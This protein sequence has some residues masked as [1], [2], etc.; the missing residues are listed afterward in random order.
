[1]TNKKTITAILTLAGFKVTKIFT[2]WTGTNDGQ[3][4]NCLNYEVIASNE[5]KD[6][7]IHIFGQGYIDTLREITHKLIQFGAEEGWSY[8][9]EELKI[10]ISDN[11]LKLILNDVK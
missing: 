6:C 7:C 9:Q 1:M 3:S 10:H 2:Y 4:E 8:S 11:N 5:R